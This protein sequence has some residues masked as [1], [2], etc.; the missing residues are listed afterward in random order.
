MNA[1]QKTE[2]TVYIFD[3][4]LRDGE[5][6]PGCTMNVQEKLKLAQQLA[7]LNVDAIEA[8]FP[9][10][11]QG[12]FDAVELIAQNVFGPAI[13]GLCRTGFADIDRAWNAIKA[14]ERPRIHTF[15]A[16][17]PVH[18]KKKLEM[19][20]RQVVKA[21]VDG[22]KRAK[23]YC[24]E[25]EFSP[26]DAS[27][28]EFDF[29]CEVVEKVIAAGATH[30]NIPDTVGYAIPEEFGKLIGN[31][32][33]HVPNSGKAIFSV[34]C[35][36]DLGLAVANSL[37][38]IQNGA[39]QCECTINGLGERAG[40]A[41]LEEIVMGIH[42]RRDIMQVKTNIITQ[43]IYRTSRMVSNITGFN[44][45]PNKAIV[46]RNAFAHEAGIHQHGVL[47]DKRTYEIMDAETVGIVKSSL[48]LGKHS[49]RHAFNDKLIELGYVLDHGM[50]NKAFARFKNLCDQKKEVTDAD[51][52]SIIEDELTIVDEVFR[53]ESVHVMCGGGAR[54]TAMIVM[55]VGDRRMEQAAIGV[56]PIDA[57]YQ[58]IKKIAKVDIQLVDFSVKSV[59]G[60]MDALGEATARISDVNDKSGKL[61]TGRGSNLDI[62]EAS[63]R[64]YVMA[65]NKM[66]H[67]QKAAQEKPPAKAEAGKKPVR[68]TA[69]KK[70]A[71]RG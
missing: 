2:D 63:A 36:N 45:Q 69:K 18:M 28:S 46:G 40:N 41:S 44:V 19:T 51:I 12:D 54:S 67:W 48:V 42:T 57:V 66:L 64:A 33:K 35:H 22:V 61:F 55:Q 27:R 68:K 14:S 60:S 24:S 29:L 17:S 52:Q 34:H 50:M 20:P 56:G 53:L 65:I 58:C 15:I 47:R 13:V 4:T 30:V 26:E 49:G 37:A 3:T 62:V 6:S 71:P 23:G 39:R 25:I 21:A 31:L 43:E 59:T 7:R 5:Q 70:A 10:S 32:I 9:M 1:K 8:G 11:S 16:T 38:A